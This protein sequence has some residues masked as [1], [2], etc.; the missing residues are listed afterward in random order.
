MMSAYAHPETLANTQWVAEHAHDPNVRIVECDGSRKLYDTGHIEGAAFWNAYSDILRPDQRVEE[1]PEAAAELFARTGVSRAMTV[2]VYSNSASAAAL[3]FWYL[4]LFGHPDVRLMD[5]GRRK[6]E[7]EG[8]PFTTEV[9]TVHRAA[10]PLV[11]LAADIRALR[12][13]VERSIGESGHALVDTRRVQEY[14]GEWFASKPPAAGERGG[15]IAGAAHINFETAL[16]A[17]GTFKPADELSVLYGGQGVT[18]DKEVTTYC[19]LGWR[20]GHTWFV[21][22]YLLGYPNV[23]NY[24]ASWNEWGRAADT[25]IET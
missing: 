9:P 3:A 6:W 15:H 23:R 16:N 21:L 7:S 18:P 25:P 19:T 11:A 12:A 5:G 8:R 1:N 17:D 24:D 10:Y 13:D 22:K 4:K 2:V 14:S 20:A